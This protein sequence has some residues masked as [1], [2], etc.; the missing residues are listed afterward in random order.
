MSIQ[1]LQRNLGLQHKNTLIPLSC[2]AKAS[3]LS[4]FLREHYFENYHP[5]ILLFMITPIQEFT[6]IVLWKDFY[7]ILSKLRPSAICH[8]CLYPINFSLLSNQLC[9]CQIRLLIPT[10]CFHSCFSKQ[11][12]SFSSFCPTRS[13]PSLWCLTLKSIWSPVISLSH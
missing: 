11:K 13:C 3:P 9:P 4:F 2:C 1:K 10:Q 8:R 7:R 12:C 6:I 5:K